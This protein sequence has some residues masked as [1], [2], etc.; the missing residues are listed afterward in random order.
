MKKIYKIF[1]ITGYTR[2]KWIPRGT[3]ETEEQAI[4]KLSEMVKPGKNFIILP[5]YAY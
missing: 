3:F 4:E 5:V 1:E 2:S